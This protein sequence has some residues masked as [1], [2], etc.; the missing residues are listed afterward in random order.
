MQLGAVASP[1]DTTCSLHVDYTSCLASLDR[2]GIPRQTNAILGIGKD[3]QMFNRILIIALA[4]VATSFMYANTAKAE[5]I[6]DGLVSYWTLDE[7]SKDAVGKNHGVVMGNPK[8][9]DGKIG[10]AL[11]FGDWGNFVD[12][13][14]DES[15]NFERTDA[16]SIQAWVKKEID[17]M[18]VI[19]GKQ[20]SAGAY[21]GWIFFFHTPGN[22]AVCIRND[23]PS[24][25]LIEVITVEAFSIAE[26][27]HVVMTYDGSSKASG[28]KI[29]VDGVDKVLNRGWD[30]DDSI[31]TNLN[32]N[33]GSRDGGQ[34]YFNG[35]IDEVG[36][37]SR[38]LDEDEVKQNF[39]AEE[40][41]LA[42]RPT[43]KLAEAW[44]KIKVLQ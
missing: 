24:K 13:G 7:T 5:V 27:Y 16:F 1:A 14:N 20:E 41:S 25:N 43:G 32:V 22:L 23:W 17:C 40:S 15:L 44:G 29:Y 18:Q 9:V 39:E 28:V 4:V 38:A 35:I 2:D 3:D 34:T 21:R 26:W 33:I 37:Y 42:V 36:V 8:T 19:L 31:K 30:L 6:R 12:C 10:K 11:Q